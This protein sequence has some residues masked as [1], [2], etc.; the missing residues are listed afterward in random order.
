MDF[1]KNWTYYADKDSDGI[2]VEL[3]HDAMIDSKRSP[4]ADGGAACAY[5]SGGIYRYTKAFDVPEDWKTKN[6]FIKFGGVYRKSRIYLNGI[7]CFEWANGYT[8]FEFCADEYLIY[9]QTNH[10]EVIA[11]NSEQPNSRWYTGGGIYR[12]VS[13]IVKNKTH[14]NLNGIRVSTSSINPPI[15][16]L[17]ASR[18][19]GDVTFT[20]VEQ[21][22]VIAKLDGEGELTLKDAKLWSAEQPNLYTLKAVLTENGN[23]VDEEEILFGIR[24]IAYSTK[25]LFVNGNN[26]LLRG[27]CVHHD[28]G[29]LG[30]RA[31]A[32]AE[33]RKARKIK[34]AGFNAVRFSHN[35]CSDAFLSACDKVGLYVI[36][37]F[38]DMWYMRK[39]KYDYALD[40]ENWYEKDIKSI[41]D[42]DYNHTSVIMYSI[43][44]ELS[45]PYQQKGV[46][47]AKKLIDLFHTL[48]ATR[49][50]TAGINLFIINNAAKGKGQ[51]SEEKVEADA[52]P[53]KAVE[54]PTSSTLFNMIATHAGPS[55]NKMSN[56]DE[57]DRVTSPVLDALDIAGYNYASGRYEMEGTKHPDRIIYGS[58]TFP[59]DIWKNW[60]KVK[61]LPY[62]F[63][64]FMW[65]AV[66][67]LGE[68]GLG[69]WSYEPQYGMTFEKPYPWII[70]DTGAIDIIG[71]IGAEAKYAS[72]VWGLENK[73]FIAVYPVNKQHSKL[74]KSVW[75][76]TNAIASWAWKDC[77]KK[78]AL[79]E[80]YSDCAYVELYLNGEYIGKKKLKECKAFFKT[81]YRSGT[82]E[83]V[84]YDKKGQEVSRSQLI[85]ASGQRK[86]AIACENEQIS[87]GDV[88]FVDVSITGENGVVECNADQKLTAEITGGQLLAFGSAQQKTEEKYSSAMTETY[89]GRALLVLQAGNEDK[90]TIKIKGDSTQAELTISVT[91]VKE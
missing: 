91:T 22:K 21:G 25:G 80:V 60:Q 66:D 38:S 50:V 30:A 47:T 33:E 88:V 14:F 65:T 68:V 27:G 56:S 34:E 26:T 4:M 64:D 57:V 36:D 59:Q 20:V 90:I 31:Y 71:T 76:G 75:R 42:K 24:Q 85:S 2:S 37:E 89:Y 6:I 40:F 11:D 10:I 61:A 48:D 46:D 73:P 67:Y 18:T 3:P 1:N 8:G 45:E 28:N 17:T 7:Q 9:G 54:K 81:G 82:L 74:I 62:L 49:A 55:M 58:E 51:Y 69:G 87:A 13:L 5:F 43:G 53:K 39:K 72:T 78:R 83:A 84:A 32:E 77:E 23:I 12:P 41:V 29:I 70:A 16:N 63:G 19:G 52:Q 35:P 79:I 44:N 15:I 86:I